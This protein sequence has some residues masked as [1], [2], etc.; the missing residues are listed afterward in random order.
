MSMEEF[1]Y[2]NPHHNRPVIAGA[3]EYAILLP[4]DKAELFAAKLELT[5]QPLVSWQA[6]RLR[7][8]ETVPQVA[9]R[10]GMSVETLR[11]VNGI[12]AKARVP[13][14]PHAARAVA[15][16]DARVG[17]TTLTH[18]VTQAVF[19]T[20]PQG[21][22]FY[23]RV[24]RGDTLAAHR[25]AL[26]RVGAGPAPLEQPRPEQHRRPGSSCGSRA[27][28]RRTPRR[29]KR[30]HRRQRASRLPRTAT[31]PGRERRAAS[32]GV[33]A[34]KTGNGSGERNGEAKP[35]AEDGALRAEPLGAAVIV[36]RRQK[37]QATCSTSPVFSPAACA[38]AGPMPRRLLLLCGLLGAASSPRPSSPPSSSRPSS[39]PSSPPSSSRP[40]HA[41]FF[42]AFFGL[43]LR[44]A[45][46]TAFFFAAFRDGLLLRRLLRFRPSSSARFFSLLRRPPSSWPVSSWPPAFFFGAAFL[47]AGA[48]AAAGIID[49]MSA[50][51][52]SPV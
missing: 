49:I 32:R 51:F 22:T 39:R 47:G 20:V 35:P 1:Q 26:R 9:A 5:D 37:K 10:F 18:R 7:T 42:A 6:Y 25:R 13:V 30:A 44:A 12:G 21:R 2:L 11:A 45:F 3:D 50:I 4:I 43:L 24:N 48:A 33:H 23:Y 28:S 34:R 40:W 19:T 17:A 14:G 29:A 41:F 36:P 27:I 46:F 16:A 52:I 15:A 38:A 8:G 31:A